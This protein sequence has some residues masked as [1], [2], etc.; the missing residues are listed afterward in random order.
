MEVTILGGAAACPNPGQGS[1]GYLVEIDGQFFLLD[2][3]PNTIQELRQ[4]VEIDQI[5]YILISH[6]HADHTIDLVPLRYGL[7][8]APGLQPCRPRL[9]MPP[10]GRAFLDRLANAFAVGTEGAD[11]FFEETYDVE[12]YDPENGLLLDNVQVSFLRT[13]HPVPCWAMK[14]HANDS[15]LVYLADTGPLDDLTQFAENA[16]ILI[17]EGTYPSNSDA[18]DTDDRPHLSASEAG[19]IARDSGAREFILTHLWST[20]GFDHYLDSATDAF[21]RQVTLARPGVKVRSP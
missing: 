11:G 4:H 2:C 19:Q 18:P 3:G 17:C 8:Y 21:G 5:K 10:D 12:Q 9:Y 16:D 7:K 20:A 13:N 14:L 1:A 6:V 15:T